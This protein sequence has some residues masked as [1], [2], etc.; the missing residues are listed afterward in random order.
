MAQS[1]GGAAVRQRLGLRQHT[2]ASPTCR[3]YA[4]LPRR[5]TVRVMLSIGKLTAAQG[6]D[7]LLR[8]VAHGAEDYYA[9]DEQ[10]GEAPGRWVASSEALLGLSG[11]VRD[12]AFRAVYGEHADPRSGETLGRTRRVYRSVSERLAEARTQLEGDATRNGR[13][14]SPEEW[15][16][17]ER[18]VRRTDRTSVDAYDLTFSP[19]KSVSVLW[20]AGDAATRA[21]VWAAHHAAVD[22]ALR[23]LERE[24]AFTRS[25]HH[26]TRHD[27]HRRDRASGGRWEDT[28]GLVGA[29]FD[30]RM[31]RAG[32]PQIHSH[33]VVLNMSRT[34]RDG[35]WRALDGQAIY[36]AKG[37][38]GAA[39]EQVLMTELSRRL[40]VTWRLRPDGAAYEVDGV[41]ER[42]R[43][44]FSTRRGQVSAQLRP[45]QE[46]FRE[47]YGR[48]PSAW[49]SSRMAQWAT[50]SNRPVKG[51]PETTS[52]AA[53]PVGDGDAGGRTDGRWPICCPRSPAGRLS[54]SRSTRRSWVR[55]RSRPRRRRRRRGP[56][57]TWP[58]RSASRLGGHVDPGLAPAAVTARI[59]ALTDRAV[60]SAEVVSLAPPELL[61]LPAS[62]RRRD[63]ES[64][65]VAPRAVRYATV[66]Q[67]TAEELIRA[68]AA[69][70]TDLR[71]GEEQVQ[72]GMRRAAAAAGGCTP[73]GEQ[74]QVVLAVATSGLRVQALVGPAGSGKTTTMATLAEVWRTGTGGRVIGLAPSEIAARQLEA[75]A[76]PTLAANTAR[77]LQAAE[78]DP[79]RWG[80]RRGDLVL[81]DEAGMVSDAHLARIVQAARQADARVLLVG[82]PGQLPSPGAGAAYAMVTRMP[83]TV[84]LSEVRRFTS[85]VGG[86]GEPAAARRQPGRARRLRPARPHPLRHRR[87]DGDPGLGGVAGRHGGRPLVAAA[88]RHQRRRR[89]G[90]R[91]GAG[92][93]GGPRAGRGHRGPHGGVAGRHPR[94]RRRPGRHPPQRPG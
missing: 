83:G 52:A 74:Q 34:E 85:R 92:V 49:E 26:G 94:R 88:G 25:G 27:D 42:L 32:D 35:R 68:A 76:A 7:Y 53:G 22:E 62:L 75:E 66:A 71:L 24:A 31:S 60:R 11:E 45:M 40:G 80:L 10:V 16:A 57:R 3:P 46:A 19:V 47:R 33:V 21:A 23:V 37:L 59:E 36:R 54:P 38:G 43:D 90:E 20:A 13:E 18:R 78:R 5:P 30:H 67:L 84:T 29:R 70:R 63:G 6:F 73:S 41:S 55:P 28:G 8:G 61:E 51:A 17:T 39:Y 93:A 14:V 65:Y 48:E 87:A 72:A 89:R 77:W 15:A 1:T 12:E 44:R 91:P 82:D 2:Y 4:T 58:A 79:A 50:L 56:A 69:E 9:R 81:L 86:G 64:V